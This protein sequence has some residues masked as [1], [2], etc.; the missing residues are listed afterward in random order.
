MG[1]L[2]K[3]SIKER[4]TNVRTFRRENGREKNEIRSIKRTSKESEKPSREIQKRQ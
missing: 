1:E 2:A 4:V 3:E